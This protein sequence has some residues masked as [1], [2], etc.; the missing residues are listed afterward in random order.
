VYVAAE[1]ILW[2]QRRIAR[3]SA[4]ICGEGDQTRGPDVSTRSEVRMHRRRGPKPRV[5]VQNRTLTERL[6][7]HRRRRVLAVI[8][9]IS[10][11]GIT[12]GSARLVQLIQAAA[13]EVSAHPWWLLWVLHWVLHLTFCLAA[14]V[15]TE[16]S[17]R[18]SRSDVRR[19]GAPAAPSRPAP[20]AS[21]EEPRWLADVR[22]ALND[23]KEARSPLGDATPTEG[24]KR[25]AGTG[26]TA[27]TGGWI[28]T[29]APYASQRDLSSEELGWL[30][31][32]RSAKEARSPL[33][34]A[35]PTERA[36][37]APASSSR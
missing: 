11:V 31:D 2:S 30:A 16:W 17:L 25:T 14:Y 33:G 24:D 15:G 12:A 34:D 32:L 10:S 6:R 36:T 9:L 1:S 29:P 23:A 7:E 28:G 4:A 21:H 20:S 19:A 8:V 5:H 3:R 26:H 37:G 27:G 13:G 35:T 22:E 18:R